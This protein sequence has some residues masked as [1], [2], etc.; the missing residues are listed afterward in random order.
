MFPI[1]D[2]IPS[3]RFPVVNTTIIVLTSIVFLA[4]LAQSNDY[5]LVERLGMI[6]KRVMDPDAEIEMVER[7]A[8]RTPFGIQIKEVRRPVQPAAVPSWLTLVT[9]IFLHG[10]WMHVIGNMWFLYIFG[11]NVEDRLGHVG[12]ILFYLVCGVGASASHLIF[13]PNSM[14]PTIGASGAVAGVMGAYFI[15]YPRATVVA[16]LPIFFFFYFIEL[17]APFF[18]GVWFLIQFF[19]GTMAINAAAGAGVAWWAHVGGFV[20]GVAIAWLLKSGHIT[21]PPV[22]QRRSG[23]NRNNYYRIGFRE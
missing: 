3:K 21:N 15:L 22:D 12:Y 14:V 16:L 7:V 19:Q 5:N 13:D 10:G 8:V 23:A 9:C 11:D 2:N 6:P 4:Q 20:L 17:P 18:L 1:Y